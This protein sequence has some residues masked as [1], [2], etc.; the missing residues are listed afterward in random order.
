MC[1]AGT[2]LIHLSTMRSVSALADLGDVVRLLFREHIALPPQV[3]IAADASEL[4]PPPATVEDASA[5]AGVAESVVPP[6]A[7][8]TVGTHESSPSV[9]LSS[10][11]SPPLDPDDRPIALWRAFWCQACRQPLAASHLPANV[12]VCSDPD[13]DI[14]LDAAVH[15]ARN[16]FHSICPDAEFLPL[17]PET[18]AS[19]ERADRTLAALSALSDDDDDNDNQDE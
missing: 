7:P 19:E 5:L 8:D 11:P 10:S 16:I 9:P 6:P 3:G 4:V 15:Q 18:A 14:G 12:F 2:F 17:L 1:A 13:A